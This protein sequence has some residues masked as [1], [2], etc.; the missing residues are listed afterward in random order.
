MAELSIGEVAE[1]SGISAP[2]LRYY[3]ELGILP[4]PE[5]VGGKRR[6]SAEVLRILNAVEVAKR[7]GF[8]L[9][10]V[11][12]L[13]EMLEHG[14][15]GSAAYRELAERK[16]AEVEDLIARAQVMRDFLKTC[17]DCNSD[18][19][20]ECGCPGADLLELRPGDSLVTSR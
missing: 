5:R 10:E 14:G 1:R 13:C 20:G 16:L 7:A 9:T 18:T 15:H 12:T 2:T 8:T 3:E 11:R 6:Y 19:S 4:E 17:L